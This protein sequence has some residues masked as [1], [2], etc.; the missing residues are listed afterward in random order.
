VL[1]KYVMSADAD[2]GYSIFVS[3]RVVSYDFVS[4]YL[5]SLKNLERHALADSVV[6]WSKLEGLESRA[7]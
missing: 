4:K 1:V 7:I 6:E 5:N 2:L 3:K